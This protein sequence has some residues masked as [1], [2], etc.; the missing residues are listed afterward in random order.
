MVGLARECPSKDPHM[1]IKHCQDVHLEVCSQV[2]GFSTDDFDWTKNR[3]SHQEG[4]NKHFQETSI[5]ILGKWVE[6]QEII[7]VEE[8][9][10]Y[11]D[12]HKLSRTS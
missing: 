10:A 4:K 8:E 12:L 2:E 5:N 6:F 3:R 9:K 11:L 7:K 1:T